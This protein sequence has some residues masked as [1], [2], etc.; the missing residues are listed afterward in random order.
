M[1]TVTLPYHQQTVPF[2]L[3]ISTTILISA[4][5]AKRLASRHV[6]MELSSN[7]CGTTP[8]LV[9]RET[10]LVWR[11]PIMLSFPHIGSMGIVGTIDVDA[12]NGDLL[13]DENNDEKIN[14]HALRLCDDPAF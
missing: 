5:E 10:A 4:A 13:T 9:L 7:L 6:I 11:V 8:E 3:N 1:S 14:D 2:D 12:S